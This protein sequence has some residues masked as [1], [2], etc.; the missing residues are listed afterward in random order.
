[1]LIS[2]QDS[3]VDGSG[4]DDVDVPFENGYVVP[5]CCELARTLLT[6]ILRYDYEDL[7]EADGR[8]HRATPKWALECHG[9]ALGDVYPGWTAPNAAPPKYCPH[10]ATPLPEVRRKENPPAARVMVSDGDYCGTCHQRSRG[11]Q[12]A[13]PEVAWET[14]PPSAPSQTCSPAVP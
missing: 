13:Y 6:V 5:D 11:C 10:C 1:M 12:C 8:F 9:K 7:T 4:Y 14:I 3:Y 2:F